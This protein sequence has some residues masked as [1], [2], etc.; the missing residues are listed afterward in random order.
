[1][2]QASFDERPPQDPRQWLWVGRPLQPAGLQVRVGIVLLVN[3]FS[4][5]LLPGGRPREPNQ[6][7]R[8]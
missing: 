7:V 4:S 5:L 8:G 6:F 2:G 3:V 1:M